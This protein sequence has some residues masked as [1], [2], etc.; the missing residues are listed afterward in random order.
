METPLRG[1]RNTASVGASL[2][3]LLEFSVRLLPSTEVTLVT[4]FAG[5]DK[6]RGAE[7]W[8]C[9]VPLVGVT[10]WTGSLDSAESSGA[11]GAGHERGVRIHV[12]AL[13]S[14]SINKV[15]F[16]PFFKNTEHLG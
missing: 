2:L 8:G 1:R 13:G 16:P 9:E 5:Q 4:R 3:C 15:D 6:R 11:L 10:G 12:V 7:L 14:P